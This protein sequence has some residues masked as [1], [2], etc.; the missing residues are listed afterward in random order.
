MKTRDAHNKRI[1]L[2]AASCFGNSRRDDVFR[3]ALG[4]LSVIVAHPEERPLGEVTA[5]VERETN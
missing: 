1:S 4:Y 3:L 2:G 5:A